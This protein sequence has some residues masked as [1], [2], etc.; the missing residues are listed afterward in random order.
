VKVL[1]DQNAPRPLSRFLVKHVVARA[2]ELGWEELANADLIG[3]AE[4]QGFEVLVTADRNLRHQQNLTNRKLA[5]VV[6]PWGQW[7]KVRPHLT[8][9]VRAVDAATPGSYTE[10]H[11]VQTA[12]E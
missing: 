1:F 12:K 4:T 5:I 6:L 10:I 2:A 3:V 8:E 9:V 7:F 11:R